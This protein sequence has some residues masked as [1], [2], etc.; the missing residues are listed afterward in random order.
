M[1]SDQEDDDNLNEEEPEEELISEA[2]FTR[3]KLLEF[4]R[5][6]PAKFDSQ[7]IESIHGLNRKTNS[8]IVQIS[9]GD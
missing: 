7:S 2:N 4:Q 8:N 6:W 3:K 5:F 1:D 9:L